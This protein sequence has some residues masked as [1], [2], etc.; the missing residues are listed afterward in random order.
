MV[1]TCVPHIVLHDLSSTSFSGGYFR[2]QK[3]ILANIAILGCFW[4]LFLTF[5]LGT[6]GARNEVGKSAFSPTAL[7]QLFSKQPKI[8]YHIVIKRSWSQTRQLQ[9][10]WVQIELVEV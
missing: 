7:G 9:E 2:P 1:C 5:G 3:S 10:S 6:S 4:G 8:T